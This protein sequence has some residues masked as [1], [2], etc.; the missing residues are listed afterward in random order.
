MT[1]G[2][3]SS[4]CSLEP[5]STTRLYPGA[6]SKPALSQRASESPKKRCSSASA[7]SALQTSLQT[8]ARH[9]PKNGQARRWLREP[10][11]SNVLFC[12]DFVST[13]LRQYGVA[14]R[15]LS[16]KTLLLSYEADG[17]EVH[18]F[19]AFR[20]VS[21]V[22][23][24]RRGGSLR[25]V[26]EALEA[27]PVGTKP[28]AAVDGRI[29]MD[30]R[31]DVNAVAPH[32]TTLTS[33]QERAGGSAFMPKLVELVG[34]GSTRRTE[35]QSPRIACAAVTAP[36]MRSR[37]LVLACPSASMA[38]RDYRASCSRRAKCW[39]IFISSESWLACPSAS[40]A[41]RDCRASCSWRAKCWSIFISSE[42]WSKRLIRLSNLLYCC[43]ERLHISRSISASAGWPNPI[44]SWRTGPLPSET[45]SL[46]FHSIIGKPQ[47]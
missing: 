43:F 18:A 22:K 10:P 7:A 47:Y 1:S 34:P 12:P 38:R 42:S 41:R 5:S 27:S 9:D 13:T 30:G 28:P 20:S 46:A 36:S 40:M 44:S 14:D 16:W 33:L 45:A 24:N 17:I 4:S 3:P 2:P 26:S 11:G 25:V 29:S 35:E 6:A 32:S 21:S 31:H 23:Q 19:S 15:F 37:V 8:N 39:S